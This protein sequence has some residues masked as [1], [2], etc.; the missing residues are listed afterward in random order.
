MKLTDEQLD[1]K[2]FATGWQIIDFKGARHVMPSDEAQR[3]FPSDCPCRPLSDPE[4][5]SV[6]VH[7]SY[8]GREAFETGERKPS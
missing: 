8:D 1:D 4:D 7:N 5:P 3:H 6:I 2:G